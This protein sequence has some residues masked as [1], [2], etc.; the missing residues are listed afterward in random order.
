MSYYSAV[1]RTNSLRIDYNGKEDQ[2]LDNSNEYQFRITTVPEGGQ[3]FLVD[4]ILKDS[5]DITLVGDW[6]TDDFFEA[7]C[8]IAKKYRRTQNAKLRQN[9]LQDR[10]Y[11]KQHRY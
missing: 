9:E 1:G 11:E 3:P 10:E 5:C 8:K 6:E 2:A 7:I 4:G